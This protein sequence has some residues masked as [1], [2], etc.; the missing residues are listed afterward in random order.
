M[1][2]CEEKLNDELEITGMLHKINSTNAL[3]RHLM[4]K[5]HRDYMKYHKSNVIEIES[6]SQ[7]SDDDDAEKHP[8]TS[9]SDSDMTSSDEEVKKNKPPTFKRNVRSKYNFTSMEKAFLFSIINDLS[10]K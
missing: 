3:L 2:K 9:S 5:R 8:W 10:L 1:E 6:D 7:S 4:H